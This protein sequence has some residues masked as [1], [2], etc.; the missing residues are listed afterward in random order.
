[1][2]ASPARTAARTR[3]RGGAAVVEVALCLTVF[4]MFL[5]GVFEYSRY[6]MVLHVATNA[7]RDGARY[8]SVNLDKGATFDTVPV[9]VGARTYPS[10]V[11]Y[12]TTRMGGTNNQISGIAI[13]VFPCDPATM[14]NDPPTIGPKAGYVAPTPPAYA[15]VARTTDWNSAA[16]TERIAVRISGNYIPSVPNL[17]RMNSTIPFNVVALMGSEG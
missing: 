14:F 2:L 11:A 6:L 5:F 1:M 9:T 3:R 13:S 12:T 10:V 17:L 8:A 4:F 7:A 16:F 15:A